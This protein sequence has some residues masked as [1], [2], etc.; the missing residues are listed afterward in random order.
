MSTWSST[1]DTA[2]E[3]AYAER[4]YITRHDPVFAEN[5]L[6]VMEAG[7][8][9]LVDMDYALDDCLFL[10]STPGHTPGH[11]AIRIASK[12]ASGVVTGDLIHSPLQCTHPEWGV[13]FD[14]QPALAR[15]TRHAFLSRYAETDTLILGTHFPAPSVGRIVHRRSAFH[16]VYRDE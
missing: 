10:E 9:V 5:V 2:D 8:G 4:Q 6:P 7:R 1:G 3:Y 11:C 15:Q 13:A 16:F 14:D 12:G